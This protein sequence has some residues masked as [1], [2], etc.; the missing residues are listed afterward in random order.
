MPTHSSALAAGMRHHQGGNL[1]R[2]AAAYRKVLDSEPDHPDALHLLG[3][4]ASER[5]NQTLAALLISQA[6]Q[7]GGAQPL[8]CASLG[9]VLRRQGNLEGAAACYLQSLQ[10]D[11]ANAG[12]HFK[13]GCLRRD[14]GRNAEAMVWLERAAALQTGFAEADYELGNLLYR[15]NRFEEAVHRYRSVVEADPAHARAHFNLGVALTVL[16]HWKEAAAAYRQ[17]VR[18]QPDYAEAHNN[19]GTLL[20]AQGKPEEAIRRYRSALAAKP[21]YHE[22]RYNLGMALQAAGRPMEALEVYRQALQGQPDHAECHNNLGNTLVALGRP[23][24]ALEAYRTALRHR[25]D[26]AEAHWNLGLA[27][28][29]LGNYEPGWEGYEWRSRRLPSRGFPQPAWD[30]GPLEGRRI[31]L[32]AE[33]GLGDTL[34]FARYVPLVRRRGGVVLLECQEPL[35]SVMR[36]LAGVDQIVARGDPLP[37]FECHA[38][39]PSLP[40]LFG[41]SLDTIPAEVPYVHAAAG[42]LERWRT[43]LARAPGSFKVGLVWSGNPEQKV[44]R[45][46]AVPVREFAALARLPGVSLISLQQGPQA[47]EAGE[48]DFPLHTLPEEVR[49]FGDTAAI[50]CNLDLVITVDTAV[51]HL[52][53]AL[54]RPVWTLLCFAA[55]WRWLLERKDSPWYPGMRLFR[56]TERDCW[57]PVLEEVRQE[58][59]RLRAAP[60]APG[61]Q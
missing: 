31:L 39:L 6:M 52:A 37:E 16:K 26:D 22:A 23:R 14:Q 43:A 2:A 40:R 24:E 49:D 53:G 51:A 33:Q 61:F 3:V 56:Q 58:L 29:L 9:L 18:L 11:P 27:E 1:R 25:P 36:T 50:V 32:H 41:T 10:G 54:G 34:H 38:A 20:H 48:A 8:Y 5:G 42:P 57:K 55:D 4:I 19:L 13:L 45:Y 15:E 60:G 47:A 59:E 12:T 44:N 7:Q 17:A 30:G 28:L 35:A 46:R 21:E